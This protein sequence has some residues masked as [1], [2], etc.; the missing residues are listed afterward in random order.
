MVSCCQHQKKKGSC[1]MKLSMWMIANRLSPLM[2][3][4]VNIRQDAKPILNSARVAYSTNTAHVYQSG[5][6]VIVE[7]EG[8][9]ILLYDIK[10]KEAFDRIQEAALGVSDQA[11]V[12]TSEVRAVAG[13]T[14]NIKEKS[15]NILS[16]GAQVSGEMENVSAAAEEQSASASEIAS[17][18]NSLS[19]LAQGLQNSLHKFKF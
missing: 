6:N 16:K 18:S 15:A 7:G 9:Q 17:A 5:N 8:D 10:L 14:E 3:I 19:E 2:D 11:E 12:I 4:A 13:Q 1:L